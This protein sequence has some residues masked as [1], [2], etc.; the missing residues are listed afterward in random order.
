M[1]EGLREGDAA[2]LQDPEERR[3][4]GL[5]GFADH[6]LLRLNCDRSGSKLKAAILEVWGKSGLARQASGEA[7]LFAIRGSLLVTVGQDTFTLKEGSAVNFDRTI[8]HGH[9]PDPSIPKDQLPVI[10]L[11]VQRD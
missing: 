5:Y 1:G 6:F 9:Q 10:I 7:L 2:A 11:Y 3:R 4:Q 8:L